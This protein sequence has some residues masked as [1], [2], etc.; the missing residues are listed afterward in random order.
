MAS[1]AIG[2]SQL[3][4]IL[5]E[6]HGLDVVL[7]GGQAVN[8]WAD[9]YASEDPELGT[10]SPL[11]SKDIDFHGDRDQAQQCAAKLR[12]HADFS[13][14]KPF[15]SILNAEVTFTDSEGEKRRIEF[16]RA[17][18]G[19]EKKN[20]I[21]SA[22]PVEVG[23][24]DVLVMNPVYCLVSRAA[25]VIRLPEK[26]DNE[27]GMNQLRAA[28]ICARIFIRA[29]ARGGKMKHAHAWAR[30]VH[31]LCRGAVGRRLYTEKGVDL[32]EVFPLDALS[33]SF[34]EKQYPQIVAQVTI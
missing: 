19:L 27:Q 23:G 8:F 26:Y 28:A 14:A 12:G 2:I 9:Y 17:V 25:N 21:E 34:R 30:E 15:G 32:L 22:V 24:H 10:R 5:A 18:A 11:T 6:L 20:L 16:I 4:P 1:S 33:E 29:L 31:A 3:R 13:V 7:V